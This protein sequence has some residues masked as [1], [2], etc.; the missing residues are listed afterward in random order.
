MKNNFALIMAGGVGTRL[1]PVSRQQFP[2]QFQ[3]VLD[4]GSSLLQLTFKRLTEVCAPENIFIISNADY[5]HLIKTQLPTISDEQIL[6]EPQL[7]NTAPCIAYAFHKISQKAPE[8]NLI[9]APAD[10]MILDQPGFDKVVNQAFEIVSQQD[11]LVTFGISPSRPDTG[12]GYIEYDTSTGQN[13][14]YKVNA[15]K[16]KPNLETAEAFLKAGNYVWKSGIFV[17][18]IPSIRKSFEKNLPEV[19]QLFAA[20]GKYYYSEQEAGF[21][22]KT[23]SNCMNISVDYGIMEKAGSAAARHR[24]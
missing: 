2:K 23:Y 16:E 1:W 20:G 15:F 21:I 13:G 6:S 8:A 10:H 17:W 22:E 18:S 5:K 12:Y 9:V 4:V 24:W 11:M 19:N 14:L 7:R 3:D